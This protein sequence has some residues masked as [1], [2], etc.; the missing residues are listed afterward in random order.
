MRFGE[1][2][3]SKALQVLDAMDLL[4][5]RAASVRHSQLLMAKNDDIKKRLQACRVGKARR[6]MI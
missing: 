6:Y 2:F 3:R 5:Q 4:V 1:L